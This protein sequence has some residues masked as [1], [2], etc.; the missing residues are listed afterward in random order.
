M[1]KLDHDGARHL[2][3]A[4]CVRECICR[5]VSLALS[6]S[7]SLS[8]S[9]AA[10]PLIA[11]ILSILH[12][13]AAATDRLRILGSRD[14]ERVSEVKRFRLLGAGILRLCSSCFISGPKASNSFAGPQRPEQRRSSAIHWQR[15]HLR[16]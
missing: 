12:G 10:S 1:H 6:L 8:L 15:C 5:C 11:L 13:Y 4:L 3:V 16:G 2:F 14:S 9:L 7:L